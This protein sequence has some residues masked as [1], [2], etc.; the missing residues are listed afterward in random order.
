MSLSLIT[1]NVGAPSVE[2]AR[3]QLEW[4]AERPEDIFVLTETKA[5]PGSQLLADACT[6][7]NYS[8]TFPEHDPG[9]LGIMIVSKVATTPD[10]LIGALS[11]LPA[12]ATG[13]IVSTSDGPLRVLGAYVPSR[14]ATL[15]KTER[16]K[17]WIEG[18][19]SALDA[20]QS[21]VPMLLVGDLNV[22]EPGHQPEHPQQFAP[23]EYDF[24]RALTARHGLIDAFRHL[25]P[26]RIEHS[27][28]RRP[29]LGYR[30]DHAHSSAQL[31]P[32]LQG[33]EY[34]HQTRDV[35][36]D[37]SRLTDHSG[38]AV[39]LAMTATTPLLTSDPATAA[40]SKNEPELEPTLF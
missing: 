32:L 27:W 35:L 22:L 29:D 16:K 2:R 38:L 40:P 34:V 4:L 1:V 36:A 33:C 3:R 31:L 11:Y 6:A 30:Y 8:V 17:R 20:T 13:I 14:D 10:P 26:R 21:G 25:H 23:F 24:Y 5:T 12:R 19:H 9:E 7:A 18:F 37:G 15:D 28:A 39:R